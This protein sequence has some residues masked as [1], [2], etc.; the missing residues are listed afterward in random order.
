[1]PK[2]THDIIVIGAGSG[3]LNIAGF[4]NRVGFR[5][6]LIDKSDANIGGDCLNFGCVPSKAL[7]HVASL[8]HHAGEAKRFL[9]SSV[10]NTPEVDM[11]LVKAYIEEKREHIRTHEHAEYFRNKGY[12]VVL[13][14]AKFVGPESVQVGTTT[15]RAKKI[16]LATGSRPRT[17]NIPGSEQVQIHTNETIFDIDTLPNDLLVIGG[18]PIGIELGQAFARLGSNVTI[19]QRGDTL[20]PKEH[21][22]VVNVLEQSLKQDGVTIARNTT[23]ISFVNDHTLEVDVK[24]VKKEL[25]F[26]AVLSA[27]G[28]EVVL[29]NLGLDAAGIQTSDG[30]LVLNQYLQTTNPNVFACGDV[31]GQYQ[32]THAAELHASV[33]ISNFFLP[34]LFW[35]KLSYDP[36]GWV[37]F[38]D[39]EIATFGLQAKELDARSINYET[40]E[41][42][43]TDDDR[44]IVDERTNG[45]L[46]LYVSKKHILGGTMV[47]R[48]AGELVQEL[49]LAQSAGI[50]YQKLFNK[51]Y[52]YPT[53]TRIN[54]QAIGTTMAGRLSPFIKKVFHWLY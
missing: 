14:E 38:T 49:M 6:L 40:I 10:T 46:I 9:S 50:P 52:P 5:V 51:I 19:V 4:M 23:P 44:A 25:P 24:G 33:I 39:P 28:R 32:F 36:F 41:Q 26:D 35:K 54:K 1:M 27:I 47:G 8:V 11:R 7:I 18:G 48:N 22:S 21:A 29:D 30:R 17:L 43:F 3:G 2:Y 13:G 37:T 42:P 20:L 15:Y 34:K 12:D 31:A 16:I 53:A 45:V